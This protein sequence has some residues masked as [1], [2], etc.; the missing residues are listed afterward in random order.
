M[1]R[2]PAIPTTILVAP[3]S[4]K[5]T[6]TARQVAAAIGRGLDAGGR[7]VELCPI[8]DG[9]EGT[10]EVLLEALGGEPVRVRVED[11]LGRELDAEFGLLDE[12]RGRL[13]AIVEMAQASGL[14]LVP[15][16]ERD[17]VGASTFGTGQLILAA[18]QA[19]AELVYVYV[20]GGGVPHLHIHLAPHREGDAL[21]SQMI[22]GDPFERKL[23]S[24]VTIVTSDR[25]P[26]LPENQL[27]TVAGR[28]RD[29]LAAS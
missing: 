25:Y 26:P 21:S 4:F 5:G 29:L 19:G 1:P 24:G 28:V 23:D 12:R 27:R 8:A 2:V 10:L 14:S 3:D 15:E 16:G 20:F 13:A 6:F 7:P 9:G 18:S 22:K 17:P 11:P